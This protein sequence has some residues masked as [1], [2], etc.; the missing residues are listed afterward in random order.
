MGNGLPAERWVAAGAG[1]WQHGN[2]NFNIQATPAFQG[3]HRRNRVILIDTGFHTLGAVI[4]AASTA[5]QPP[6]EP[7]Q[8]V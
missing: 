5:H 1:V 2:L 4:S 3:M 7:T 6:D 8:T